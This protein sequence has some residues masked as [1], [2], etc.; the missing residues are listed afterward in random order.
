MTSVW[1]PLFAFFPVGSAGSLGSRQLADLGDRL[2]V[3][4][5]D[6][7]ATDAVNERGDPVDELANPPARLSTDTGSTTGRTRLV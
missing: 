3:N 5:S 2:F 4:I 7:A 6:D 1:L